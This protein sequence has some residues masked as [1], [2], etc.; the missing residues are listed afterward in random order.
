M[1]KLAVLTI[2][3]NRADSMSRL[4]ASINR[5]SYEGDTVDL[6]VSIDH[7]GTNVVEECAKAFTWTHGKKI[8][9]TFPE[10]QGLRKHILA[11][12]D[13][14][15]NYDAIAVLE[16]DV[17]VAPGFYCYMKQA[18]EKYQNDARVA[19]ISLY[20]HL[21]NVNCS[22]PFQPA[23]TQYD[24][25]FFQ[26][27]QS[28]GQV[29][30]KDQWFAFKKWYAN[31]EN[32]FVPQDHIPAFVSRWPATSWLKYHIKYCVETDKYFVYPYKALATCFS[33]VGE[34]CKTHDPKYQISML[35]TI[36]RQYQLP[37]FDDVDVVKYD[38]FYERVLALGSIDGIATADICVDLYGTKTSYQNK[39]YLL[40]VK[41]HPYQIVKTYDLQLR[42]H[43]QN[44]LWDIAGNVIKLYDLQSSPQTKSKSVELTAF[45]YYFRV[46]G[47]TKLLLKCVIDQAK[48][49][50]LK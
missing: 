45:K 15:E 8:I 2:G 14:L 41:N 19:G 40:S 33:D 25:Y 43:E 5:A 37:D 31:Q 3:Y 9:R 17:V 50:F 30:L 21:W 39:R 13:F 12:G 44:F 7:S 6:I 4:L 26:F 47:S 1:S 18:V 10:R 27:A 29:W 46:Y 23:Y 35:T 20:N 36:K 34:H 49:K 22:L 38:A 11:C 42:P 32:E 28:W 16:D 24:T 48:R